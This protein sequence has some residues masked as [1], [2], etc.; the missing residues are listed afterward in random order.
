MLAGAR[1][2]RPILRLWQGKLPRTNDDLGYLAATKFLAE[3]SV[4]IRC[5]W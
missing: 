5:M 2:D 3:L 4:V 1:I